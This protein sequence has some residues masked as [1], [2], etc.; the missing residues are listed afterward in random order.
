[1]GENSKIE[2]CHHSFNIVWGCTKVSPACTNCYAEAWAKRMGFDVWGPNAER[3]LL[4]ESYWKQPLKWNR[5][6]EAEGQRKRVFCS[7]MA[8]VFEDH[9]TVASQRERLWPLIEQTP[10]LDWLL[11]SKRPENMTRFAPSS[12]AGGWPENAWALATAENQEWASKRITEL[13]RVP[14][15]IRGIS[16]EPLLGPIDFT[17]WLDHA[18][19][20]FCQ[21][22]SWNEGIDCDR[23]GGLGEQSRPIDLIIVG[24]ESGHQARPMHPQWVRDIRAQCAAYNV[25]FFF[26]QWGEFLPGSQ[27][28]HLSDAELTKFKAQPLDS[29]GVSSWQFRVG[30]HLAGRLLDGKEY[31]EMPRSCE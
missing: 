19:C 12:W 7:S 31:N 13:L 17:D 2:W 3:R 5:Q 10:M 15:E 30:K 6:A 8:D 11:L 28:K 26:K 22:R 4:S 25:N 21:G 9:P 23:C 27:A 18:I 14:A 1:M 20:R 24:G 29:E 16:A